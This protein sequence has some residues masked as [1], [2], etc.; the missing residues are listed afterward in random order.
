MVM[1]EDEIRAEERPEPPE[2]VAEKFRGAEN[3]IEAQARSYA[4]AE[5]E[6]GRLRSEQERQQREFSEALSQLAQ[7]QQER[8][9]QYQQ[10][11]YTPQTDPLLSAAQRA[12]EE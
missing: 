1:A 7:E 12:Y 5:K 11:Q 3:P 4:E 10:Q 2:W 9:Q 8:Q 6:M